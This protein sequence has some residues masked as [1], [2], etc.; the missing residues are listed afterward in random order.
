MSRY[1]LYCILLLP[2]IILL[3]GCFADKKYHY[4][5]DAEKQELTVIKPED[6]F[7]MNKFAEINSPPILTFQE[8]LNRTKQRGL[9]AP[10]TFNLVGLATNAIKTIITNEQSKYTTISQFTKT[11]LY[12][13]DQPSLEGPI[14]P[15]GIQFAGFNLVRTI[16]DGQGK[17]DTAF[18]ADFQLDT[19]KTIEIL[20]S[21]VFRLKLKDFRLKYVKPKVSVGGGRKMSVEF[22]ISFLTSFVTDKADLFDSVVLGKFHLLLKDI[23]IDL[24]DPNFGRCSGNAADLSVSGKSF[25][26]PRSFGYFKNGN[27]LVRGYNQGV[28]SIVASV[29]ECTK[30]DFGTAIM[31]TNGNLILNVAT[32]E[33]YNKIG[34]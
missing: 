2:V 27:S 18:F 21:S 17:P 6:D 32:Q 3:T 14:D 16:M 15:T 20:N 33:I 34:N 5:K 7:L 4:P 24:K 1:I 29:K 26:V 31:N 13:Y 9:L 10:L 8:R 11:D 23:S 30:P 22:D 28:Y 12:F 19:T 25:I